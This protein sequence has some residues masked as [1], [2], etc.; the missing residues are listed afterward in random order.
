[1]YSKPSC[2]QPGTQPQTSS[3]DVNRRAKTMDYA[4]SIHWIGQLICYRFWMSGHVMRN[5]RVRA[6]GNS[7]TW[8]RE[9]QSGCNI[10]PITQFRRETSM[11]NNNQQP[12]TQQCLP[13][14]R[15]F[16]RQPK[17]NQ[18][19][20]FPPQQ[21]QYNFNRTQGGIHNSSSNA[22]GDGVG[23]TMGLTIVTSLLGC[24]EMVL[25]VIMSVPE[26]VRD[27]CYCTF[28]RYLHNCYC[29]Y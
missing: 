3:R 20:R 26:N 12:Q 17:P 24:Y 9:L 29:G 10:T 28:S 18:Q 4:F 22:M 19:S 27:K 11:R 6:A 21:P 25:A 14:W 23:N 16:Q 5:C 7:S 15:Q 1:M 8:N 2:F 13:Q